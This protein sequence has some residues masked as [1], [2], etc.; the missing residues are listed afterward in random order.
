MSGSNSTPQFYDNQIPS[1]AQWNGGFG[2]KVDASN[3]YAAN[4]TVNGGVIVLTDDPTVALEAATK[5]YVDTHASGLPEAPTDGEVY[6]RINLTWIPV[7]SLFGGTLTGPLHL[8][9]DPVQPLEAA[10][11]QYVDAHAAAGGGIGDAPADGQ[12]YL[13]RG[14]TAAWS[15]ICDGGIF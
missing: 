4:L 13:R 1:T 14:D 6:G 5:R 10:T 8:P 3:G 15:N 7:L 2:V 9:A 11:K 12:A